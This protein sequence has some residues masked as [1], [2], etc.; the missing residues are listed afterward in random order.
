MPLA[1]NTRIGRYK[2]QSLLGTGGM[3]EVYLAKDTTLHRSVGIKLLPA[4]VTVS[5]Q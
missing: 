4:D 2:I 1:A 3:G 5:R